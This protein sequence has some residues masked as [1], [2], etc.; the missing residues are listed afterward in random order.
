[1][2]DFPPPPLSRRDPM[3]LPPP[4]SGSLRGGSLSRGYDSMFSRRSPPPSR[5]SNGMGR[6]GGLVQ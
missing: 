3:P 5:G 1:M 2:R 6:Y 4:L